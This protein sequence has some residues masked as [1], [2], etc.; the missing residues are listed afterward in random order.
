MGKLK[1]IRWADLFSCTQPCF[2]HQSSLRVGQN[3]GI[4]G[5]QTL[6]NLH[7]ACLGITEFHRNKKRK[8]EIVFFNGTMQ[9]VQNF[10]VQV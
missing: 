3:S 4:L 7:R 2:L 10:A 1:R 8:K 5:C 9:F 6:E